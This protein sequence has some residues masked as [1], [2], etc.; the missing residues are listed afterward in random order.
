[1]AASILIA[2][3][4]VLG[5]PPDLIVSGTSGCLPIVPVVVPDPS[6]GIEWRN[7][8]SEISPDPYTGIALIAAGGRGRLLAI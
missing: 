5:A 2:A 1:L 6:Y 8:W 7:V 3:F 4:P